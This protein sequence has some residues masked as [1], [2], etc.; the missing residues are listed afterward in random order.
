MSWWVVSYQNQTG[1]LLPW[2]VAQKLTNGDKNRIKATQEGAINLLKNKTKKLQC[3]IKTTFLNTSF[4]RRRPDL[5]SFTS[6][7]KRPAV[8]R[9]VV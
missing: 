1:H 6:A 2:K 4:P 3:T 7:R 5:D 9:K 8:P